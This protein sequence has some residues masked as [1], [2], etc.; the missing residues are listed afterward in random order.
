MGPDP[1]TERRP[2]LPRFR[3]LRL[4]ASGFEEDAYADFDGWSL[5]IRWRSM[6][7]EIGVSRRCS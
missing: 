7:L 2:W 6:M 3:L 4:S 1:R 5:V